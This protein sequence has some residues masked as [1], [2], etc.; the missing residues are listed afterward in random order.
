MCKH[1]EG[2][3]DASGSIM[4]QLPHESETDDGGMT[5]YGNIVEESGQ[6]KMR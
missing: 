3:G 4:R 2:F 6:S 1:V 5:V